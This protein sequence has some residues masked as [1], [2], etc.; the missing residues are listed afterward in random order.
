[1]LEWI[2]LYHVMNCT[3]AVAAERKTVGHVSSSIFSKVESVFTLMWMFGVTIRNNHLS[4]RKSVKYRSDSTL[5]I[6]CDIVEDNSFLVIES[7]MEVPVLPIE[8]STT[9]LE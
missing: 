9:N 6:V 4:E 5:V 8:F 3:F 7:D 1:M 2:E